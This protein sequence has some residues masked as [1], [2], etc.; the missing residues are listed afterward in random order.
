MALVRQ[1]HLV[2]LPDLPPEEPVRDQRERIIKPGSQPGGINIVYPGQRGH[3][4]NFGPCTPE[5]SP[6]VAVPHSPIAAHGRPE[7]H[8]KI[9]I[10]GWSTR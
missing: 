1:P 10:G 6:A 4:G 8:T 7:V 2:I 3:P 5:A 9:T